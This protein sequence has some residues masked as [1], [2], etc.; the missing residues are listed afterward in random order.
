MGA[1]SAKVIQVAPTTARDECE[2]IQV[3]TMRSDDP[4]SA[5]YLKRDQPH[6]PAPGEIVT[7]EHSH[8]TWGQPP[9]SAEKH[10]NDFDPAMEF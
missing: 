4:H 5:F 10:W 1:W 8:V 7:V 6:Y 9:V 2:V 3:L